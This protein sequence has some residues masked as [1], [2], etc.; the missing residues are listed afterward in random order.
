MPSDTERV[1]GCG[2]LS[3]FYASTGFLN[4]N[5]IRGKRYQQTTTFGEHLLTYSLIMPN[6]FFSADSNLGPLGSETGALTDWA[7]A[8][9]VPNVR[10]KVSA[11]KLL[12]L[13]KQGLHSKVGAQGARR[14][15][16]SWKLGSRHPQTLL[17][18]RQLQ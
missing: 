9:P 11:S 16:I 14:L 10:T 7:N 15:V 5:R 4:K 17:L 13:L 2:S 6:V 3:R 8:P 1:C 18:F 12:K